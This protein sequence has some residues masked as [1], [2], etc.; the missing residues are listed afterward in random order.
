MIRKKLLT[1]FLLPGVVLLASCKSTAQVS[2]TAEANMPNPA[3]VYCEQQ[4]NQ[5]EIVTADDG[6]QYG[7]CVFPDGQTCGEWAYFRNECG[8]E[9][10]GYSSS[11]STEV[12]NSTQDIDSQST[13][14]ISPSDNGI[15]SAPAQ[16]VVNEALG[17]CFA[18]PKGF[19]QQFNDSQVEVIGPHSN[20]SPY[21]GLAWIDAT[22]AQGRTTEEIV[23]E[24][25]TAFGGSPPRSTLMLGDEEA[26]MLDGMPGQD[27]IRKVYIVHNGSLYTLSFSPFQSGDDTTESQMKTLFASVTSSWNWISSGMPCPLTD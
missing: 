6:S 13:S 4:G 14:S 9:Q 21:P 7:V 22:G 1:L 20:T 3:S 11:A 5:L 27:P 18:Y 26:V 23:E 12:P 17:Y 19:T 10:Q 2:P 8:P 25:V 24:E 16:V 15:V